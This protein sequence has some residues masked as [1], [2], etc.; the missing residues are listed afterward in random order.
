[1]K[2]LKFI[3]KSDLIAFESLQ[4]TILV[5]VINGFEECSFVLGKDQISQ[6]HEW[7]GHYLEK[8]D[9]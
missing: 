1:M 7:L 6:L 9:D 8:C 2:D 4:K 3:E 5:L